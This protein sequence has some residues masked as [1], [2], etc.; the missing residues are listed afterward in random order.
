MHQISEID[1]KLV[2][3]ACQLPYIFP[4]VSERGFTLLLARG[5]SR[6]LLADARDCG[7][8]LAQSVSP[9]FIEIMF[10]KSYQVSYLHL[11]LACI[12]LVAESDVFFRLFH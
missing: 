9:P 6:S 3:P 2:S 1:G 12:E 8:V 5:L 7:Y 11:L 10:L 4:G